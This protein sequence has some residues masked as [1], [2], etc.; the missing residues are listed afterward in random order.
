[1]S[2]AFARRLC[3]Y[4]CLLAAGETAARTAK[5]YAMAGFPHVIS[6]IEC[7]HVSVLQPSESEY[8]HANHKDQHTFNVQLL[9]DTD[10]FTSLL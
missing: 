6:C 7:T 4:A 8:Q 5:L 3:E 10:L 2:A 9:C 1:M